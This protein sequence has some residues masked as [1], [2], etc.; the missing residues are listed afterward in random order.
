MTECGRIARTPVFACPSR[1]EYDPCFVLFVGCASVY[2][3]DECGHG[4][5]LLVEGS[6]VHGFTAPPALFPLSVCLF[7]HCSLDTRG[8]MPQ[9]NGEWSCSS[10]S[11]PLACI[12]DGRQNFFYVTSFVFSFLFRFCSLLN[13]YPSP[14]QLQYHLI[15]TL[16]PPLI[17]L[18]T[19]PSIYHTHLHTSTILSNFTFF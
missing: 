1:C 5:E 6:L 15:P 2:V 14:I 16:P 4:G 7:C 9:C 3:C 19:T 8:S 11:F 17:P 13:L 10:I 18:L 12:N